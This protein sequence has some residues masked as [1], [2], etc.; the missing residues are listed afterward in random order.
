MARVNKEAGKEGAAELG[1]EGCKAAK[2]NQQV[3]RP[4]TTPNR[5]FFYAMTET[6]PGACA[7]RR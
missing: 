1:K 4:L 6:S 3:S 2:K 5:A 7:S